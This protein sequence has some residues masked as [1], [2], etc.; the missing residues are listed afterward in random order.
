MYTYLKGLGVILLAAFVLAGCSGMHALGGSSSEPLQLTEKVIAKSWTI[1]HY[2]RVA[3]S[4]AERTDGGLLKVKLGLEN[5]RS[6]DLWCDIQ[7]IFY[8]ADGFKLDETN[9]Q[10]LFMSGEQLT[11]FET[12]SM[13]RNAADYSIILRDARN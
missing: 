9:W 11:F 1:K 2:V 12:V 8:D 7:T 13:N 6:K 10:P 3:N 4:K 5:L